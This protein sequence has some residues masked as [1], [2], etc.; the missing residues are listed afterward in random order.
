MGDALSAQVGD[1]L[2]ELQH[3][4]NPLPAARR[5]L[6][7]ELLQRAGIAGRAEKTGQSASGER[8]GHVL[9]PSVSPGLTS[10]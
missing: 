4:Q 10:S 8:C 5:G 1:A 9:P 7:Q 6:C 3:H 2:Q